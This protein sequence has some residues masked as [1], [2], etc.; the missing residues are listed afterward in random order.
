ME[1][2][3]KKLSEYYSKSGWLCKK[4]L[5][6]RA[7]LTI[8]AAALVILGCSVKSKETVLDFSAIQSFREIPC[9][10][11]EEII[12]IESLQKEFDSLVYGIAPS[13]EAFTDENGNI[14]GY[15]AL[16]CEWLT[17][18]F[19]IR[20]EMRI[21]EWAEITEKINL[22]EIDFTVHFLTSNEIPQNYY[23]SDPVAER[24]FSITYL[25][26]NPAVSQIL[27]EKPIYVFTAGSPTESVIASVLGRDAYES[28][29]ANQYDE[30]YAILERGDAEAII[31]TKAAQ[32]NFI[33]Y[34]NLIHED[35]FPLTYSPVSIITANPRFEVIINV[36]NKALRNP[37]SSG[38]SAMPYL[39]TL[40]DAGHN[41]YRHNKFIMSLNG[42]ERAYLENTVS[43]PL[44]AQYFNYPI[45]FF[46]NYEKKWDGITFDL[47]HEVERITGLTFDVV[48]GSH[49]EMYDLIQMLT[50][51]RAHIF[52]DL[53]FS[54]ERGP[55]FIWSKQK[56][57]S[58]QYALLSK[59]N[60]PNINV[61]EIP[62]GRIALI[63]NTA[64]AEMY[65]KWFPNAVNAVE[66]D[67]TDDAF[68]KL[69][70]DEVDMVMAAKSKLLYYSNYFEFSGYKVNYL[71]NY[72]YESAFAF[73]KEQT[74]LCSIVDKA[75]SVI[76]TKIIVEQWLTRTYDYRTKIINARIPWL[77]GAVIMSAAV[78]V[79]ILVIYFKNAKM[80]REL[81]NAKELAEQSNRA[82][83]VFLSHMSH[84]IRTPM[85]AI[86]GIAEIQ[87]RDRECS[88]NT[89]EA[90]DKIYESGDLLLNII[91]D[92]LDLSKIESGKMEINP[93][94]YDIP[95]LINDTVQLNRLRYE[96]NPVEFKIH[97][98]ENTPI[99]L[100][101]DEL[102]IKQILNNIL[103]N[104]FK[105]TNEGK[106][107]FYIS[108][109]TEPDSQ[110]VII[111]FRVCDT[112]Q[113]MTENQMERLFDEYIRFN[114]NTNRNIVGA[115]L[116][117]SI[118]KYLIDL[119]DGSIAVESEQGK[120][121]V[122]T[123]RLPQKRMSPAVC[124]HELTEKL[125]IFRF[126]STSIARKTQFMRE[127][128]P[129]GSVLV[130]DDVESNIFVTKGMLMPYGLK[131]DAVSSGI[132][133]I[134]KIKN[135]NTYDIVFMDHMMPKMDGIEAVKIIRNFGYTRTIVALTANALVGR[136]EMFLKN[137]FNGF[138]SKPIDSREMNHVLNE[139][140]RNKKP[141]EVVEAARREQRRIDYGNTSDTGVSDELAAAAVHDAENAL[142]VLEELFPKI[143][144]ENAGSSAADMKLFAAT[145]HGMKSALANIGEHSLS[146]TAL[147]LEK[148]SANGETAVLLAETKGFLNSLRLVIEKI[149]RPQTE[150]NGDVSGEDMVF[151]RIKLDEIKTACQKFVI[152][153]A[154]TALS[155][156]KQKIWPRG[157]SSAVDEISLF[158]IRGEFTKVIS[159]ADK[160]IDDGLTKK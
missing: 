46:N 121:S 65:K 41:E 146:N 20:F 29:W 101:G 26:G 17:R 96:S 90:F 30:A 88:P 143:N 95:S 23:L 34:D 144:E 158:L 12:S 122:F 124:G 9:V 129:Y 73:N 115:G 35:F 134:E 19:G 104:A 58:D 127:F 31:T 87:L 119:M 99:D 153:D 132:E 36:L 125:R 39:N 14:G 15:A 112:G 156:L 81:V 47:L 32:A 100:F 109:E 49:T 136:A 80:T 70:Q 118:T 103:S 110:N 1:T 16:L 147:K 50:D 44:A 83:S 59:I 18:L 131:I 13:T 38:G 116:G 141:P 69:E 145:V 128:M 54:E 4:F 63:K 137:G 53:V 150:K 154:K 40:Y 74:V 75:L 92:I 89:L 108:A 42:E 84:E 64:H 106:I 28:V 61:N 148:A 133:A 43:V 139:Y 78:L 94:N 45:V 140:I 114:M 72:S 60:F 130:V 85:N 5:I 68:I 86:L 120:G 66:Y 33:A 105:Y 7:A 157:I 37:S 24:Q 93:I 159:A 155:Q 135:G 76:D 160:I 152:K 117:M 21:L 3:V 113:G 138:I 67:A 149:K 51:G 107:D 27:N 111:I 25:S 2:K 56:L 97:V 151:L 10:T 123:V 22:G 102:R 52:S 57:M 55:H 48:N 82:K 91:N 142:A 11:A 62:Y 71:F 6:M 8:C 79:L 126:Q 98:D 77:I